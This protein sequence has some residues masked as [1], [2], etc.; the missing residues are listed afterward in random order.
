MLQR[1]RHYRGT[2][3]DLTMDGDAVVRIEDFVV[4]VPGLLP[5]ETAQIH[6]KKVKKSFAFGEVLHREDD[7]PFRADPPCP[8]FSECGGCTLQHLAY[9]AQLD[10]KRNMVTQTLAR[11]AGLSVAANPVLGMDDPYRS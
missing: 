4:F 3:T 9:S 6:I 8:H 5:N 1:D 2:A 7:S 11:I 10:I